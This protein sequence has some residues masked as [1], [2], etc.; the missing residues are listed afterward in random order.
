MASEVASGGNKQ[1]EL[2]LLFEFKFKG[3]R[4]KGTPVRSNSLLKMIQLSEYQLLL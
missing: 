3:V 1:Q 2:S 4:T